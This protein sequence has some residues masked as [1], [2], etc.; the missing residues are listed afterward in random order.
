MPRLSSIE[1]RKQYLHF[2]AAHFT[3]FSATER[4]RLHGHN[5]RLGVEITGE[6]DANGLC[7]DYAIYKKILKDLCHQYDEYTL[8]ADHSPYLQ[9][10]EDEEFYFVT[11]NHRT[12]PLLKT[13]TLLLPVK[14]IT[15]EELANYF[16][17]LLTDDRERLEELKI[18][19]FEVRVSSGPD[20]WGIARWDR[21]AEANDV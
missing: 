2:S 21:L 15:I 9:I 18:Y 4:E 11:H 17:K 1:I 6:I 14:N 10:S 5:W 12:Q 13:D 20:Q 7:F 19:R 3:I 16:L 8:I